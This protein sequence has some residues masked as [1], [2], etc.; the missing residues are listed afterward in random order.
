MP[1]AYRLITRYEDSTLRLDWNAASDILAVIGVAGEVGTALRIIKVPGRTTRMI[2]GLGQMGLE[3]II[4]GGSLW[5]EIEQIQTSNLSEGEKR[6]RLM[7]ALGR[8][9]LDFGMLVGES[10]M[11]RAYEHQ[12]APKPPTETDV[13]PGE[14]DVGHERDVSPGEPG[15]ITETETPSP[16]AGTEREGPRT[17]EEGTPDE[18]PSTELTTPEHPA[19]GAEIGEGEGALPE[20]VRQEQTSHEA[21]AE[22]LARQQSSR[23]TSELPP[24]TSALVRRLDR[25][26]EAYQR[27]RESVQGHNQR[28]A[29]ALNHYIDEAVARRQEL[30]DNPENEDAHVN[31]E[32]LLDNMGEMQNALRGH[33]EPESEAGTPESEEGVEPGDQVETEPED[34]AQSEEV[35]EGGSADAQPES[36]SQQTPADLIQGDEFTGN[37][38]DSRR[39]NEL[40]E[41]YKNED[42]S[43]ADVSPEEWAYR[44]R[45][46]AR[47][48]LDRLLPEGWA[49]RRS[50]SRSRA[51]RGE[52]TVVVTRRMLEEVPY[53]ADDV[54]LPIPISEGDSLV[55]RPSVDRPSSGTSR[56]LFVSFLDQVPSDVRQ[57]FDEAVRNTMNRL[58]MN[59]LRR[60]N[61]VFYDD[62]GN[63]HIWP[64]DEHGVP[65]EVHHIIELS[66]GG[67]NAPANLMAIEHRQHDL[68][69]RWWRRLQQHILAD[70]ELREAFGDPDAQ[71]EHI[72]EL[73]EVLNMDE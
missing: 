62:Q 5:E 40:Y 38:E 67:T 27:M 14:G 48:I 18:A 42:E 64:V 37:G 73:D 72:P 65:L 29:E 26:I 46:E 50:R 31:A 1:A 45:G 9:L 49:R 32:D 41:R 4:I 58:D 63:Q 35:M 3:G 57:T 34:G 66:W 68:L 11:Q 70:P 69:S 22:E 10:M 51:N 24:R 7:Q 36:I 12:D 6:T 60:R 8:A 28:M 55:M 13:L 59:E 53:P 16:E 47:R 61:L 2:M 56:R 39:L 71:G 20:E 21:T 44:T 15:L 54:S 17:V 52:V 43:R 19:E 23:D 33:L 25:M 30:M